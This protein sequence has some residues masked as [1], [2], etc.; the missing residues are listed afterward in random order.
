M[1][2]LFA[3]IH[4]VRTI[5]SIVITFIVCLSPL[6]ATAQ[7]E[8]PRSILIL[9]EADVRGG[10]FYYEVYSAFRSMVNTGSQSSVTIYAESLDLR[11]FG[12]ANYEESLQAH[13]D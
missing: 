11:R 12:G 13:L 7:P 5:F 6:P 9:D 3:W 4:A 2:N 8:R 1:E 10:P